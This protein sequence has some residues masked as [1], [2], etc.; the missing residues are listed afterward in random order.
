M[1]QKIIAMLSMAAIMLINTQ[2][3]FSQNP[4]SEKE[5]EKLPFTE[6]CIVDEEPERVQ[7]MEDIENKMNDPLFEK[8]DIEEPIY[9]VETNPQFDGGPSAM[10]KWISDNLIYPENVEQDYPSIR[11]I[12]RVV[13]EKDG[14]VTSPTVVKGYKYEF[15][16]SAVKLMEKMPKWI[17]G[18]INNIPVRCYYNIPVR[19][20]TPT[21]E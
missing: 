6:I 20:E 3:I 12:V 7:T 13:I 19:F 11:V 9:T 18:K 1:R 4:Q 10:L 21:K 14:T 2:I 16:K 5:Y 15:D 17:P 8:N